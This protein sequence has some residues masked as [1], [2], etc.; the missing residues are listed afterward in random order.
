MNLFLYYEYYQ[1]FEI[2]IHVLR[3][4]VVVGVIVFLC[5][6]EFFTGETYECSGKHITEL[7]PHQNFK[8]TRKQ[9]LK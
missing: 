5:F 2:C 6:R 3:L 7:L 9:N 1:H 8:I 4:F